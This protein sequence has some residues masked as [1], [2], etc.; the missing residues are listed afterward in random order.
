VKTSPWHK[1]F[2]RGI[3]YLSGHEPARAV[4]CFERALAACPETGGRALSRLLYYQGM[5]LRRLGYEN[6]AIRCWVAGRKAWKSRKIQRLLGGCAN[7][8]GMAKQNCVEKDDWQAFYA[9]QQARYLAR[10]WRHFPA[11]LPPGERALLKTLIYSHW[12]SLKDSGLLEGRSS[13]EKKALFRNYTIDFPFVSARPL[14]EPLIEVNFRTKRKIR[15]GEACYCGSGLPYFSCCGRT[16]G[17]EE[18]QSGIF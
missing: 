3:R 9:L 5:A 1:H 18:L 6:T 11:V 15:D 4:H 7:S 17:A 14:G 16:P 12:I 8:Y 13:A 2:R 10:F